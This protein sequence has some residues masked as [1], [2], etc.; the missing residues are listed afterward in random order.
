MTANKT[1]ILL[2]TLLMTSTVINAQ[3]IINLPFEPASEVEWIGNEKNYYSTIWE[4][5]V[6]TNVSSP[7]MQVF[8]PEPSVANGT[9]VII[10]PGGGLYALS[11]ESEGNEVAK[12]LNTKGIT[13][14]V[15]KYR[16]VPTG[17]DGVAEIT[18]G[19]DEVLKKVAQVLPLS[20]QDGLT[21]LNFVRQNAHKWQLDSE[22]IGFMG[23]SA[24]GA[25]AMGVAYNYSL[26]NRPNFIIPIYP[27]TTAMPVQDCPTDA[28]P[29][30]IVCATDDPLNLAPGSIALYNSWL[31]GKKPVGLHMYSK[32]G[33]GFGMKQQGLPS[34]KWILR[35]YE[36]LLAE[37][38][39]EESNSN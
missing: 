2:I 39:T 37:G 17:K 3:E 32:G 16:L 24:G 36:W 9:S 1:I 4:N 8:R 21:A 26:E 10:A 35:T 29:I 20:Y 6:V 12:W 34:D 33:H 23:F 28:P 11:I 13:A 19:G 25:V 22:K 5:Q 30:L 31:D 7:S 15:L 27:W 18:N 14:F 38:L